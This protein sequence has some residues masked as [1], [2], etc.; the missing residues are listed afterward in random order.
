[1]GARQG[2]PLGTMLYALVQH[3]LLVEVA[4]AYDTLEVDAFADDVTFTAAP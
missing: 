3:P 1:M 4:E 2:C